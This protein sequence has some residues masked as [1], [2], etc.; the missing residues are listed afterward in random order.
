MVYISLH[1]TTCH[2]DCYEVLSCYST[3][4]LCM[5]KEDTPEA[6]LKEL[7]VDKLRNIRQILP[8]AF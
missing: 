7:R 2:R 8:T 4:T 1:A 6:F 5:R 3:L